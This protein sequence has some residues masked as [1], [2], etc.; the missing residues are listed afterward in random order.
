LF[1]K[2]LYKS[3]PGLNCACSFHNDIVAVGVLPATG[4]VPIIT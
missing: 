4:S 3:A 2:L 1:P